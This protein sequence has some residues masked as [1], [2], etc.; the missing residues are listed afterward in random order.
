M[1]TERPNPLA[2]RVDEIRGSLKSRDPRD[3][4]QKTLSAYHEVGQDQGYFL[5]EYWGEQI[6]VSYPD[7][8]CVLESDRSELHTMD[9]A[10]LAYYFRVSDGTPQANEWIA[11]TE[12]PD[13]QF[14]TQAFQGYT[15]RELV[16]AFGNDH[17][18]FHTAAEQTGGD[19]EDFGDLAFRFQ[20]LPRVALVVASW[21]GDEDFPAS[22][23]ILFDAHASHHLTTDALAILGSTLTRKLLK[24]AL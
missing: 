23:R 15:G 12:L 6:R 21:L 16:V 14:Y 20:I 10:M 3:L 4:A 24:A 13:G 18:K 1:N 2:G 19:L 17:K 8:I 9:Q 22:Y 11:F 5:L 7:F